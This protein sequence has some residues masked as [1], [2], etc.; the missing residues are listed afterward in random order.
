MSASNPQ[1]QLI[2]TSKCK[3]TFAGIFYSLKWNGIVYIIFSKK[4]TH[5]MSS[6]PVFCLCKSF[7]SLLQYSRQYKI[8]PSNLSKFY[9]FSSEKEICSTKID[10]GRI[11][12]FFEAASLLLVLVRMLSIFPPFIRQR[13]AIAK[14]LLHW[15]YR[16]TN[17]EINF[18]RERQHSIFFAVRLII[19]RSVGVSSV[20]LGEMLTASCSILFHVQSCEKK[21]V[22][23]L[24]RVERS[25]SSV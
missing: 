21:M 18:D 1:K 14:H 19:C 2:K 4:A 15:M 8:S 22:P 3:R 10:A 20:F 9:F 23:Y 12:L 11:F 16:N 24:G 25:R 13:R 5:I 6:P 7:L 17:I